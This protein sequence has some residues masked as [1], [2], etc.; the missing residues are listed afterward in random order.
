MSED[1]LIKYQNEYGDESFSA[2]I[3]AVILE[4]LKNINLEQ[5]REILVK[6][7]N[8]TKSKVSEERSIKRLK[9]MTYLLRQ[10]TN[11]NG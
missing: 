3:G 8:E 10:G 7:I 2:G 6:N 1:E 11:L 4:I 9:L 5:E